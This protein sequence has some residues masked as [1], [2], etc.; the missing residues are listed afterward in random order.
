MEVGDQNKTTYLNQ[1]C[2]RIVVISSFPVTQKAT[3]NKNHPTVD[4]KDKK[5]NK[6]AA[7]HEDNFLYRVLPA[8]HWASNDQRGRYDSLTDAAH[9]RVHVPETGGRGEDTKHG[10]P[11]GSKVDF[12]RLKGDKT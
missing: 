7:R 1:K 11:A 12:N 4:E 2:H 3:I 10:L 8:C 9:T 6:A 5:G